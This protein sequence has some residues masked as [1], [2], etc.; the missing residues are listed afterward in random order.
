MTLGLHEGAATP[1]HV[2]RGSRICLLGGFRLEDGGCQVALPRSVRRL[3][4]FLALQERPQPRALVA[5]NLWLDASEARAAASLRSTLWRLRSAGPDVV[6]TDGTQLELDRSVTVD[7]SSMCARVKQLI[8]G[9]ESPA[10]GE[11][12]GVSLADDLLPGWYDDWVI[13]A[14][15]QVRQ[16]RLRL[17]ER[18]CEQ[19]TDAGR[20]TE[21]IEI[22]LMAVADEPLRES[23]QR[24]VVRAHLAEGN[25]SEA[26]RQY[27]TYRALL[28]DVLGLEPTEQMARLIGP[29]L[30]RWRQGG[31]GPTRHR[32]VTSPA[33]KAE[34]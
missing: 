9:A 7:V 21:A 6:L 28:D 34:Q 33:V 10:G 8:S 32:W 16:L 14:R 11:L 24:A 5:A 3:V 29:L 25:W 12:E 15:E 18:L 1:E 4:A 27:E 2:A 20:F 19:L 13:A 26:L 17:L 31:G 23:A 22:G 30:P